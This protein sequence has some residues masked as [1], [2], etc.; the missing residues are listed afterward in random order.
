MVRVAING[1]GRIG[2][3]FFRAGFDELNIVAINDL[4]DINTM[5]HLLKHDSVHREYKNDVHVHDNSIYV[6]GKEIKVF[7]EKDPS[8]LPWDDLDIDVVIESTG[9]FRTEEKA[10]KHIEAGAKKV[11]LSAPGKGDIKTIVKGVNEHEYD[12][13]NHH[14]IDNA[15]CTTNCLAPIIKVLNDNF[16]VKRGF[17]T[18]IHASTADQR[19]VDAPHKDLR[20]ARAAGLNM[21]PTTTGAAIAVGRVIPDVEGKLDGMAVRVPV[22]DGSLVDLTVELNRGTNVDEVNE[23]FK[24]VAIHH[25][26]GI[27]QYSSEPLV[28]SDI[29]GNPHSS[30]F[31][32]QLTRVSD[33]NLVHITAW[34]DNE[35]GYSCRLVDVAKLINSFFN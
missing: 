31:D 29:I 32:S 5:A 8:N 2:R 17:M 22:T 23:L 19:I 6:N 16:G 3:L 4:G 14:I 21:V 9:I 18:T 26:A 11:L 12:K 33:G 27:L 30:I 28:S 34:Y 7:N 1:F 13:E 24:N 35:W 20:R 15:S 10:G 25:L